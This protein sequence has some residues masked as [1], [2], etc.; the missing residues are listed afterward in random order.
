MRASASPRRIL[1]ARA[2]AIA[3]DLLQ[4]GL[5]PFF[6]QGAASPIGDA[7]DLVVAALLV[8]LLGWHIAFLPTFLIEL[9][10]MADLFPSWTA[11]VFFV[12]RKRG[13]P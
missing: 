11:A 1:A 5:F 13:P 7:V 2:I 9:V 12:T 10:P 8:A 6:V 3:A 4:L